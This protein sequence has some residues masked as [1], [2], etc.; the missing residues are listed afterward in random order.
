MFEPLTSTKATSMGVGLSI[1]KSI[2]E[3]HYG[4]IW[5]GCGDPP[6]GTTL[7]FTL[8]LATAELKE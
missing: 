6:A 7:S 4:S 3:A 5:A 2:V 8:P 1:S